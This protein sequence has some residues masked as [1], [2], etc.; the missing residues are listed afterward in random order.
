MAAVKASAL[1]RNPKKKTATLYFLSKE[2][3]REMQ[4]SDSELNRANRMLV[5][6]RKE[7]ALKEEAY[8]VLEQGSKE[9]QDLD[10]LR[11]QLQDV[12]K[13]LKE[14]RKQRGILI[15]E[16]QDLKEQLMEVDKRRQKAEAAVISV[17]DAMKERE[18][19]ARALERSRNVKAQSKNLQKK[20]P[21]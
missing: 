21:V 20:M 2:L 13:E 14:E 17:D 16:L 18:K 12:N 19:A 8:H 1:Q 4:A 11:E 6:M 10:A 9:K 7:R 3:Q 5:E 15:Q